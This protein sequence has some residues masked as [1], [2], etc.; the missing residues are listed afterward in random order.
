VGLVLS[1]LI[2]DRMKLTEFAELKAMIV[3]FIK[4]MRNERKH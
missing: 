3:G 4:K 2:Y 1:Y